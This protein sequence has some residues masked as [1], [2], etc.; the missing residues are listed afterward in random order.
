MIA[1]LRDPST[2][3]RF[4]G[5]GSR[6]P[7][8]G[9]NPR[10]RRHIPLAGR[11]EL[12]IVLRLPALPEL[13]GCLSG[14]IARSQLYV[15]RPASC[16]SGRARLS[17]RWRAKDALKIADVDPLEVGDEAVRVYFE[18][19]RDPVAMA[20]SVSRTRSRSSRNGS[21]SP[22]TVAL[23]TTALE[24]GPRSAACLNAG[25]PRGIRDTPDPRRAVCLRQ[26]L[27]LDLPAARGVLLCGPLVESAAWNGDSLLAKQARRLPLAPGYE[28]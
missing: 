20:S 2:A 7:G 22:A 21:E 10:P 9:R 11:A 6:P 19:Q 15:E 12:A 25:P 26:H 18:H 17:G 28:R 1:S 23:H 4:V 14:R 8:S 16:S 5:R 13:L 27:I 3:R 24:D